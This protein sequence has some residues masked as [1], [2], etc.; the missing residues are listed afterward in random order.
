MYVYT[1]PTFIFGWGRVF[2]IVGKGF[3]IFGQ[4]FT[5]DLISSLAV[6]GKEEW[7]EKAYEKSYKVEN[8]KKRAEYQF[9]KDSFCFLFVKCL[10]I[11]LG[12]GSA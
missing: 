7:E 4:I 6:N 5:P 11:S 3:E 8:L 10:K 9:Q 2:S 1:L 12:S